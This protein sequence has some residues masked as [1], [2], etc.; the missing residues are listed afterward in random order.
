MKQPALLLAVLFAAPAFASANYPVEIQ[1]YLSTST[2]P[3]CS[4]CHK[5][6]ITGAGTVTTLMGSALRAQGLVS[7]NVTSLHTALDALQTMGTDSDGDGV[8][9]IDELKA[10]TDPNV[11]DQSG[12]DGGTGGGG[13]G[14]D[15]VLPPPRYGCGAQAVPTGFLGL[16]M[17]MLLLGLKRR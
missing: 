14:S 15:V 10:G 8:T 3:P 4:V 6:N 13:G 11:A 1:N 7:G 17:L 16:A 5:N 2:V 12:T 9:D